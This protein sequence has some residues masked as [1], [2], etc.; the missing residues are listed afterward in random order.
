MPCLV[1]SGNSMDSRDSRETKDTAMA[2]IIKD[3][4]LV[5]TDRSTVIKTQRC[6]SATSGC[7]WPTQHP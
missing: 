2:S 6:K 5:L 3:A 1:I 4:V 7:Q